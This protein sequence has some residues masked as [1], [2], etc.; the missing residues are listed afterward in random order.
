[1]PAA[2]RSAW[3]CWRSPRWWRCA[4]G[5]G[6]AFLREVE[7][8]RISVDDLHELIRAGHDPVV[9]DV[10]SEPSVQI[11]ARRI[12]G[13]I[14]VELNQMRSK[15]SGLPRD[16]EIIVY[17]NCPNE[18]SAA[19]AARLLAAEGLVRVRPLA[20]GLDAWVASGRPIEE[21]LVQLA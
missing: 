3:S 19:R 14:F 15:A 18:V 6:T 13:A 1:M 8:S 4:T 11:D 5:A 21:V 7:M 16:R 2:W 17:C 12:P 9:I 10:R 20:G